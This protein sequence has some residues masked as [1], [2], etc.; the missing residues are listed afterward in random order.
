[1]DFTKVTKPEEGSFLIAFAD[2]QNFG[3][4]SKALPD[5]VQLFDLLNS[6]AKIIIEAIDK[7]P[8][9]VLK[10]IG[11][12]CLMIFP[13]DAIDAGVLALL[14]IKEQ[15]EKHFKNNGLPNKMRIT[16]HYGEAAVGQ[17]GTGS[18]KSIDIIGDSVNVAAS[19]SR[20]DHR[21][22]LIISPQVF[23]KLAA[24]T[25]KAFHKYTPP[26]VY[27]AEDN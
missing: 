13:D 25:R 2:I 15:V 27:L 23:R 10:F 8:G 21:G 22:R 11:D 14:S 18:M 4:I 24:S 12:E 6:W 19:L 3:T 9:R 1:M 20:G 16:A 7:T 5:P 17:F 26:L